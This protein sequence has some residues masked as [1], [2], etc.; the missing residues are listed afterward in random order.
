MIP[1]KNLNKQ[2]RQ[3]KRL[4]ALLVII[5]CFS[6]VTARSQG[7]VI[8]RDTVSTEGLCIAGE[9]VA[10]VHITAN[11][12]LP[13]VFAS[14]LDPD[15]NNIVTQRK[16][17]SN[18]IYSLVLPTIYI[19]EDVIDET[20]YDNRI[21]EISCYSL[22]PVAVE[23]SLALKPKETRRYIVKAQECYS[24]RYQEASEL[25]QKG[26]YT[27]AGKKYMEAKQCFD[28]PPDE[29]I[30][31]KIAVIDSIILLR[32]IANES[33]DILDY[34]NALISYN[35]IITYN[36]DDIFVIRRVSECITQISQMCS[37]YFSTAEI[38]YNDHNYVN[39][40]SLYEKIIENKCDEFYYKTSL[41]R[42]TAIDD[43]KQHS[44]VL[45]YIW[46]KTTPIGLSIG[47]YKDMKTSGYFTIRTNTDLFEMLRSNYDKVKKSEINVSFGWTFRP[48]K[49]QYAPWLFLGP[50]YTGVGGYIYDEDHPENKPASKFYNAISPEIGL[51]YKIGP[52]ALRYNFQYRFAFKKEQEEYIGKTAHV[53]GIGFCF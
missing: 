27:E 23:L 19:D 17:G 6:V 12:S 31:Q 36:Q 30:A 51:L 21:L 5:I 48:V 2:T 3:G 13:L 34:N 37:K 47:G 35:K 24:K 44:T 46:S 45:S 9:T 41:E 53:L 14:E 4:C 49:V 15:I 11:K 40:K 10:C 43:I 20:V 50:G 1:Q 18:I 32:K 39:A 8:E 29:N 33:F 25:F 38:F 52:V 7:L 22:F 26:L 28:M 42:L 16:A